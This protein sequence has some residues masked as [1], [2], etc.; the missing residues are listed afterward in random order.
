[1]RTPKELRDIAGD[2]LGDI[3]GFEGLLQGREEKLGAQVRQ[4]LAVLALQR[5]GVHAL[6]VQVNRR[7]GDVISRSRRAMNAV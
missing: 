4:R 6:L 2:S 3:L 7:A 1:M 5:L